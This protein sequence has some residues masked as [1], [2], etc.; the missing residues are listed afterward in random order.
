[1]GVA[2]AYYLAGQGVRIVG[3]IDRAGGLLNPD[4]FGLEKIRALLLTRQGN[5][6]TDHDLLSFEEINEQV[7]SVGPIVLFRLRRRAWWGGR[8]WSSCWPV[9]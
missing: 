8:R 6:L 7:W 3:I 9:A 5:S 2:A 1:M 4:G